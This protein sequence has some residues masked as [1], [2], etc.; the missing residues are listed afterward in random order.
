MNAVVVAVVVVVLAVVVVVVAV[1]VGA[2]LRRDDRLLLRRALLLPLV[3]VA[4]GLDLGVREHRDERGEIIL[5]YLY[6][7]EVV[8]FTRNDFS[9]VYYSVLLTSKCKFFLSYILNTCKSTFS[10]AI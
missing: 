3:L 5:L 1:V 10:L 2:L 9:G 8:L 7:K 4:V 6:E